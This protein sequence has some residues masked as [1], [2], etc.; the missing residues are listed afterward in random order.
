MA[1]KYRSKYK[2]RTGRKRRYFRKTGYKTFKKNIMRFAEKKW[3]DTPLGVTQVENRN[4]TVVTKINPI[5][6]LD[7]TDNGR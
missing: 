1:R 3:V 2:K 5:I 6:N 4:G 7:N